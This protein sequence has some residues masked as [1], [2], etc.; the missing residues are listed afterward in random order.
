MLADC[1]WHVYRMLGKLSGR[2]YVLSR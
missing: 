1:F 2:V